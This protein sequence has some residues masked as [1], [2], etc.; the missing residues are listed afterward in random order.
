MLISVSMQLQKELNRIKC[1]LPLKK[2]R[3]GAH[4]IYY[5]DKKIQKKTTHKRLE[6]KE[7]TSVFK[8]RKV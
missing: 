5:T 1:V 6:R 7:K 8:G 4:S 2:G 3:R